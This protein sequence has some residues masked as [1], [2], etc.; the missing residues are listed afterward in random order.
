MKFETLRSG[1]GVRRV[2]R[3]LNVSE[4]QAEQQARLRK[5]ACG[6]IEGFLGRRESQVCSLHDDRSKGRGRAGHT[7]VFRVGAKLE[8]LA[9]LINGNVGPDEIKTALERETPAN[10]DGRGIDEP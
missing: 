2:W 5:T 9:S 1:H 3:F 8:I 7:S 10:I 4:C 6:I